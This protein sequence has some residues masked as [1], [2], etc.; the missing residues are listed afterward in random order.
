MK[1]SVALRFFM[2]LILLWPC[3]KEI[4]AQTACSE[5]KVDVR[6]TQTTNDQS[7]GNIA[8]V[9]SDD[10]AEFDIHIFEPHGK[11]KLNLREKKFENLKKGKYL[12]IVTARSETSNYCPKKIEVTIN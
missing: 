2:V 1:S 12:I 6:V 5:I 8:L 3:F 9:F 10:S 4:K 7:N 11:R